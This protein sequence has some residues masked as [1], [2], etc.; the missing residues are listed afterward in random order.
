M[1]LGDMRVLVTGGAGFIGSHL[2][3]ALLA[4]GHDIIVLDDLSTGKR[5][6]LPSEA[7]LVEGCV[8]DATLVAALIAETDA[9]V[10]LAAI[11]SVQR[12]T[13]DWAGTH[14][15]NHAAFIALLD[16]AAKRPQPYPVVYASSAA[17]YGDP[18]Q[19]PVHEDLPAAPLSAY[20]ADKYGCELSARVAGHVHGVPSFGLRF[21]N[22]YGPR[23]D[24]A[25][26]YSGVLSIFRR[27]AELN[28]PILIHGDGSQT[29][30]FVH[31]SDAVAALTAALAAADA[32]APVA[33]ICTGN[34]TSVLDAARLLIARIGSASTIE[35]AP[36]RSGDIRHSRGSAARA[37]CLLGWTARIGTLAEGLADQ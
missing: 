17:V 16:A 3:E 30:D 23:Q 24:P 19:Q 15:V 36:A 29:R 18:A 1:N 27:R 20:G 13:E 12:A 2:V 26:P 37:A 8:T 10:H 25:S 6:N 5:H 14:A 4:G 34:A 22:V 9:C 33:N 21:F 28:L 32:S 31:V 35:H 11:A 7:R